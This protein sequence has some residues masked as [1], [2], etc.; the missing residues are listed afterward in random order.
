MFAAVIQIEKR[1]TE[2][3]KVH[4]LHLKMRVF[5]KVLSEFKF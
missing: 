3:A 5:A 1:G 2:N 4:V